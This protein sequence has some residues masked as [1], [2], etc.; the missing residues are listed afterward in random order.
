MIDTTHLG[1]HRAGSYSTV[2]HFFQ[3]SMDHSSLWSL[4]SKSDYFK[5]FFSLM[6]LPS[7]LK[8]VV[9]R[10]FYS[11]IS[12]CR[13]YYFSLVSVRWFFLNIST[14]WVLNI[15]I[16]IYAYKHIIQCKIIGWVLGHEKV[17]IRVLGLLIS[18]YKNDSSNFLRRRMMK[19]IHYFDKA[20]G[21]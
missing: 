11:Y 7:F 4:F 18:S 15:V 20:I 12:G 16:F 2:R 9:R 5:V 10:I 8:L 13:G 1:D 6:V 19:I 21:I 17:C 14:L 3:V